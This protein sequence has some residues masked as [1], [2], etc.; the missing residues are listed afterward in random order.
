MREVMNGNATHISTQWKVTTHLS[1][2]EKPTPRDLKESQGGYPR[3]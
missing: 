2:P 1:H 3:I